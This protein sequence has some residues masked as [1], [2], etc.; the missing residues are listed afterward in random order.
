MWTWFLWISASQILN[1]LKWIAIPLFLTSWC[2][3]KQVLSILDNQTGPMKTT[4]HGRHPLQVLLGSVN[5]TFFFFSSSFVLECNQHNFL[6]VS[7]GE[8][9]GLCIWMKI[10]IC[11]LM[12]QLQIY[13]SRVGDC[14]N[15]HKGHN[16]LISNLC[17]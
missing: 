16:H 17:F 8:I 14:Q 5:L 10:L 1:L 7:Q 6:S 12:A 3:I 11:E 2:G 4:T 15:P 9:P 13:L